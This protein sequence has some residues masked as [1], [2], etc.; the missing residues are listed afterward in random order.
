LSSLVTNYFFENENNNAASQY[1]INCSQQYHTEPVQIESGAIMV[2]LP[3]T[4]LTCFLNSAL[5]SL[6][7]AFFSLFSI[8]K[9][10]Y[11]KLLK[12]LFSSY[13]PSG[14]LMQ[15]KRYLESESRVDMSDA[16]ES[17][18]DAFVVV[19]QLLELLKEE[20]EVYKNFLFF[21]PLTTCSSCGTRNLPT[22]THLIIADCHSVQ[23]FLSKTDSI[24]DCVQCD[25]KFIRSVTCPK[26]L[27]IRCLKNTSPS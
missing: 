10:R 19:Q 9:G 7:P 4:K 20:Q 16:L 22:N 18:G 8:M 6:K 27:V 17:F 14:S 1:S 3:N 5:Q 26:F 24:T 23:Q 25:R 12:E 21:S 13:Q 15:L 11:S 2:G